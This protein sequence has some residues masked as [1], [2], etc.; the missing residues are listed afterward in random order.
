MNEQRIS[1]RRRRRRRAQKIKLVLRLILL[2]AALAA[3]VLI[4]IYITKVAGKGLGN[5]VEESVTMEAG[6]TLPNVSAFLKKDSDIPDASYETDLSAMDLSKLGTYPV[7]I[8]IGTSTYESSLIIVDTTAPYGEAVAVTGNLGTSQD[9]ER[10]VTGIRDATE[11]KVTFKESPDFYQAGEQEVTL[12][13]TDEGGNTTEIVSSLTTI[14]DDVPP[15]ISG[16]HD[17]TINKGDTISYREGVT[18]VDE[19]D[20]EVT[21]SVDTSEVNTD[22]AGTYTAYYRAEDAAGNQ[23]EV[24]ITVTVKEPEETDANVDMEFVE[25]LAQQVLDEITTP[26]MTQAQI[27]WAIYDWCQ[28]NLGYENTTEK[29]SWQ[30]AALNGLYNHIGDCW[31][32][33]NTAREL[34]TMAGIENLTV[35]R[36]WPNHYWLMVNVGTGWYH[37]DVTPRATGGRFFMW[38]DAE[39]KAYSDKYDNCFSYDHSQYPATPE[40]SFPGAVYE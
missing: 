21:V 20:G 38:T 28:Y 29:P 39:L 15:V 16:T 35:T 34:L 27:A 3:I 8:R 37:Y 10:F 22:R 26:D 18:A 36:D 2:V 11:V 17:I 25:Q 23:A 5:K 24:A 32:H 14:R 13:L 40:E 12:V 19:T 30:Q 4:I 1:E 7:V 9:P 31:V 33:C 6:G